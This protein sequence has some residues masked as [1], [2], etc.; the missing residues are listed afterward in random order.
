MHIGFG[1]VKEPS[2]DGSIY[3]R[4]KVGLS[5]SC[6]FSNCVFDG[7]FKL[8]YLVVLCFYEKIKVLALVQE[9]SF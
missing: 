3:F 5:D 4:A 2:F 6:C 7:K 8:T 1:N 9:S